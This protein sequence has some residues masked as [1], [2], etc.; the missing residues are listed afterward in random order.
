MQILYKTQSK[1]E[2]KKYQKSIIQM[3][4]SLQFSFIQEFQLINELHVEESN[5]RSD[6]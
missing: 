6:S 1:D 5:S 4:L 3:N 2:D